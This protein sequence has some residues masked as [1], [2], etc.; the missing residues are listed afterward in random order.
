MMRAWATDVSR[1]DKV[2]LS[3]LSLCVVALFSVLQFHIISFPALSPTTSIMY[4]HVNTPNISLM[5]SY[6][7]P[8]ITNSFTPPPQQ[9]TVTQ[10][11]GSL[12]S[13]SP[14]ALVAAQTKH[15]MQVVSVSQNSSIVGLIVRPLQPLLSTVD[16][17]PLLLC[18]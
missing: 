11:A 5:T 13:P 12:T 14:T 1:T 6:Q 4:T 9:S 17:S 8:Q 18:K 16:C 15:S 3:F 10:T 2:F 7:A